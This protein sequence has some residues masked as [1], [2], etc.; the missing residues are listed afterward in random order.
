[1]NEYWQLPPK[2]KIY[3]A[4]TCIAD[5]RVE[6]N[7]ELTEAKIYS[8]RRDKFYTV[9]YEPENQLIMSDDN[10]AWF[11]DQVSYPMITLLMLRGE[12]EYDKSLLES[13]KGIVW[14]D[15]NKKHKNNWAKAAREVLDELAGRGIDVNLIEGEIDRMYEFI[16][17]L[18]LKKLGKKKFPPR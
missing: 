3:E 14:K 16:S 12:I 9:T 7:E 2:E 10:S 5:D 11:V 18:K 6:T 4:I 1:M 8:S 17:N 15:V 13:L